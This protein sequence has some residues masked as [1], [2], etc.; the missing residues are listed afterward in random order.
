[1]A[2][3]SRAPEEFDDKDVPPTR[4]TSETL[5]EAVR[6]ARYLWPYRVPFV[7]ALVTLL[8]GS[9]L[10]MVL[11]YCTGSLI[12][13]ALA[14]GVSALPWYQTVD[15]VAGLLMLILALQAACAYW[16]SY[17]FATGAART[18]AGPR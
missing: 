12:D 16:R 11:P 4:I 14:H 17:C 18:L 13:G 1:M 10:A 2:R 7:V 15:G 8:I 9:G 5:R 3:R 6:L